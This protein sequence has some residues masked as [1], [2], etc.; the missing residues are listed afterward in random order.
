MPTIDGVSPP[1]KSLVDFALQYAGRRWAVF[2]LRIRGKMPI[3]PYARGGRGFHDATTNQEQINTWW[4][5]WPN[6]NIGVATGASGLVVIDIDGPEGQAQFRSI[7]K[8]F[9]PTLT[10]RTGRPGG[11]HLWYSGAVPSSQV[12]GEHVDVRGTTGYVVAP[13]SVHETGTVYQWVDPLAMVAPVPSWVAEWV[14]NRTGVRAPREKVAVT[15]E[16]PAWLPERARL[17]DAIADALHPPTPYSAHEHARLRSALAAVPANVDGKTWVTIGAVLKD[18]KWI[19][20]NEDQGFEIWDEWSSTSQGKG[21]GNGEYRGRD[22]LTK[23]WISFE[24]DYGG[25]R[26]TTAT[27]FALATKAGWDGS[28]TVVPSET[29]EQKVNGNVYAFPED[30]ARKQ[31]I[32]IDTNKAGKPL[33]TCTNAGI[34]IAGLG[35]TCRKNTFHEKMLVGGHAIQ[36]WGGDLSDDAVY[37]LRHTIKREFGFDPGNNNTRDAAIQLCLQNQFNPVTEYLAGL[38]WDGTPRINMWVVT[39]LGAEPTLFHCAVGRLMLIA[40]C[41]RARHPGTKFDQIIVLEG[42]EGTGKS[43]AVKILAGEDNFSDQNIL[44]VSDKEQQEAFQGVWLHEIAELAGMRRTDVDRIKQFASRTEDRARPAY[45]RFRV[46][47]KR[48]GVFIAT[49]NDRL[50]LKSETG[51]RRFWPLDTRAVQLKALERDR[52]QLWAEAA[53]LEAGGA[54]V[55]LPPQLWQAAGEAQDSRLGEDSWQEL[56]EAA[57]EKTDDVSLYEVMTGAQ[58]RF[59]AGDINQVAQTRIARILVRLGF[60]R[61]QKR[62]GEKR[63]WRYIRFKTGATDDSG[64]GKSVIAS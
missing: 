53:L 44:A 52:D 5:Q 61:Y 3:I 56:V 43:T 31:T 22:N 16:R 10:S 35:I 59:G 46:D 37:M 20:G 60:S 64:G 25:E 26:A 33:P 7:C 14:A 28:V 51:N 4:K 45:G 62:Y 19:V 13:P 54:S 9:V 15:G 11:F 47:M 12:K 30:F 39:Y 1:D 8:E 41:R 48:R 29:S 17:A 40:A 57:V 24:K 63:H 23:R 58:F 55:L 49:T 27:I 32:F 18:L 42:R 50:Y 6:A 34:A 21:A 2:P 36:A 38:K